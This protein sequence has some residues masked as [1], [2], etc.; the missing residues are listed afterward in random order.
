MSRTRVSKSNPLGRSR[1]SGHCP[2]CFICPLVL[3]CSV[4]VAF[5]GGWVTDLFLES[6]LPSFALSVSWIESRPRDS[7]KVT[8]DLDG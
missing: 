7:V 3:I 8:R 2:S 4:S 1:D 6:A 5:V